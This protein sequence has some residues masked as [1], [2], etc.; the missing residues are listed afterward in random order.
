MKAIGRV[1]CSPTQN[2]S[3]RRGGILMVA[4][5]IL[6]VLFILSGFV[7]NLAYLQLSRTELLVATDAA[8]RAASRTYSEL[9][10]R[11]AARIAAQVTAAYNRVAG[12]PLRIDPN[13]D[14][15]FGYADNGNSSS[16][17][18]FTELSEAQL[19]SGTRIANAILVSSSRTPG[20]GSGPI[21]F[22]MPGFV[23]PN[24]S[25]ITQ[26][27]TAVQIDRD[28]ILV[29]D[30]SGSMAFKYYDW[31]RGTNPWNTDAYDAAVQA[32]LMTKQTDRRGRVTYYYAR[33]VSSDDYQDWAWSDY[34]NLGPPPKSPWEDLKIAVRNFLDILQEQNQNGLVGIA[35]YSSSASLDIHLTR[36]FAA[37]AAELD[38]LSPS[39]STAI[40]EGIEEGALGLFDPSYARRYAMKSLIIMTDGMQNAGIDPV[41]ATNNLE[42]QH[43]VTIHTVT[44]S[45]G[46]D[47]GRMKQLAKAGNGQHYHADNGNELIEVYREIARNLP[48]LTV[49]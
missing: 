11:D 29:L 27:S 39:G 12:S 26:S 3:V 8:T 31:P 1:L 25:P 24:A 13:T 37:V 21:S 30:R 36:D 38:T 22:P 6:P 16:R 10:D 40:G 4:A 34:F 49:E 9:Q 15:K 35:S 19:N 14:L 20:S 45:T 5:L 43:Q 28:I 7:I 2:G 46:A 23:L 18:T 44:F 32:G 33:G 48:T 47:Q 42:S 41:T 17:Y